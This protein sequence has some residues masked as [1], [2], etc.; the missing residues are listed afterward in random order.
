[1]QLTAKQPEQWRLNLYSEVDERAHKRP[2]GSWKTSRF[3]LKICRVKGKWTS[4]AIGQVW[5]FIH[6]HGVRIMEELKS[7]NGFYY[8]WTLLYHKVEWETLHIS[9][10]L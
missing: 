7:L 2:R 9:V 5:L 1:M 3:Y 8:A 10:I 6:P 4:R